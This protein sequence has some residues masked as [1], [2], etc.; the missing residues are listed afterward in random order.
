VYVELDG[1]RRI[2]VTPASGGAAL[3]QGDATLANRIDRALG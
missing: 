2:L 1:C 3:R